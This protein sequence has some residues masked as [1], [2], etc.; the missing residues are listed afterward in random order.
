MAY[1]KW[2]VHC[3]QLLP[4]TWQGKRSHWSD[5]F[6]PFLIFWITFLLQLSLRHERFCLVKTYILM[7]LKLIGGKNSFSGFWQKRS[8]VT[9]LFIAVF[10]N[11]FHRCVWLFIFVKSSFISLFAKVT[12]LTLRYW[13]V[14]FANIFQMLQI[15]DCKYYINFCKYW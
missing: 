7:A 9:C 5:Y 11:I 6:A 3:W 13:D 14:P 8:S 12:S 4:W 1:Y 2:F 10:N 15:D